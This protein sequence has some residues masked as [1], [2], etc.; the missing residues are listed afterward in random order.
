MSPIYM[1]YKNILSVIHVCESRRVIINQY[2]YLRE[3]SYLD[4]TEALAAISLLC[5]GNTISMIN[6]TYQIT[7]YDQ[8]LFVVCAKANMRYCVAAEFII[9]SKSADSN[10]RSFEC[11][12]I[13][14][15]NWKPVFHV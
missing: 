4:S 11:T 6:A 15:A 12:K 8:P 1:Y 13:S 2:K 14:N 7:K 10:S 9:D 5:Y 3:K